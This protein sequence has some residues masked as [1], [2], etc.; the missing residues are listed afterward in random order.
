MVYAGLDI[1][2]ITA[3]AA[4]LDDDHMVGSAVLAAGYNRAEAAQQVLDL[5]LQQAGLASDAISAL[6]ATGYG[7]VQV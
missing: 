1:G 7:R 2:A 4:L 6:V 3:K 5:A